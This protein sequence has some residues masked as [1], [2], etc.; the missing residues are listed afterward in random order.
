MA[1]TLEQLKRDRELQ[2]K[3]EQEKVAERRREADQPL[4]KRT[5]KWIVA[6]PKHAAGIIAGIV[7]VIVLLRVALVGVDFLEAQ[8]HLSSYYELA[9]EGNLEQAQ[10]ELAQYLRSKPEDWGH[11]IEYGVLLV[12]L[13][14]VEE[15]A[16]V[17]AAVS[18]SSAEGNSADVQF[19]YALSQ[20]KYD[21][22]LI[23]GMDAVL[24]GLSNYLPALLGRG[25]AQYRLDPSEGLDH[26]EQAVARVEELDQ[27]SDI[28]MRSQTQANDF[29]ELACRQNP[30]IFAYKIEDPAIRPQADSENQLLFDFSFAELDGQQQ[31]IF[32]IDNSLYLDFCGLTIA[33]SARQGQQADLRALVYMLH[34]FAQAKAG[35]YDAAAA[36]ISES[37]QSGVLP[38]TIYLDGTIAALR[39]AYGEAVE[40]L[41]DGLADGDPHMMVSAGHALIH[42]SVEDWPEAKELL[43]RAVGAGNEASAVAFNNRGVLHLTDALPGQARN[44]FDKAAELVADYPHATYNIGISYMLDGKYADALGLFNKLL[45][46]RN[47]FPGLHYYTALCYQLLG[48]G[49]QAQADLRYAIHDRYFSGHAYTL[50]G[51]IYSEQEI[52]AQKATDSYQKAYDLLPDNYAIGFKLAQSLSRNGQPVAASSVIDRIV[53]ASGAKHGKDSNYRLLLDAT[54]GEVYFALNDPQALRFLENSYSAA[55][56]PVLKT[57]LA[58]TY[59]NLLIKSGRP[60]EAAE[61]TRDILSVSANNVAI[62]VVRA[63]ALLALQNIDQASNTIRGALEKAPENYTVQ[64]VAGEIFAEAGSIDQALAAYNAAH[65]LEPANVFPLEEQLELLRETAPDD[66]RIARLQEEIDNAELLAASTAQEERINKSQSV[67]P[68][69]I[70]QDPQAI[71]AANEQI[72]KLVVDLVEGNIDDFSGYQNMAGLKIQVGD[73]SGAL[74]DMERAASID[75]DEVGPWK[76]IGRLNVFLGRF[77]AA[78]ESYIK[79]VA[80]E[81]SDPNLHFSLGTVRQRF[82]NKE[83][84]I[85]DFTSVLD[86]D[87]SNIRA[88]LARGDLYSTVERY[89]EALADF[90]RAIRLDDRNLCAYEYRRSIYVLLGEREKALSDGEIID[91][92]RADGEAGCS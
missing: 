42:K 82:Q 89:D 21:S 45:S 35:N 16:R 51:D 55:E 15:A 12:R 62:L 37:K 74:E 83:P 85:G 20:I 39:G 22:K 64:M 61:V 5:G 40:K 23:A 90:T 14:R 29:L 63:R 70:I 66:L 75:P 79:A 77:D 80:L 41:Q 65:N 54:R 92:L 81:P 9:E 44:D 17:L 52:F 72:E 67:L 10:A 56:D 28:Y 50:F 31:Y 73:F 38:E 25:A 24:T 48:K 3:A 78:S 30:Q 68:G 33:R 13:G 87:P 43:T 59:A 49:Y 91:V 6:H 53:E 4:A 27:G 19:Y 18:G 76:N 1:N 26:Y 2:R 69:A 71:A 86:F 88:L 7:L 32:G 8:G 57:Q 36:A 34:A 46:S 84:A 58:V 60:D 47:V 11:Q